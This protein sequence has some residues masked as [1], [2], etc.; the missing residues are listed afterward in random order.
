M[1]L[2]FH[3]FY[4]STYSCIE[5]SWFKMSLILISLFYAYYTI[6]SQP[7]SDCPCLSFIVINVVPNPCFL[8]GRP[9]AV[10]SSFGDISGF[11]SIWTLLFSC[12]FLYAPHIVKVYSNLSFSF[13]LPS[14]TGHSP[15][16]QNSNKMQNFI[17]SHT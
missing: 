14:S 2:F 4:F 9:M 8:L 13:I 1:R 17:F 15:F 11:V 10:I 6:A 5:E 7:S 12:L 3:S 16:Q